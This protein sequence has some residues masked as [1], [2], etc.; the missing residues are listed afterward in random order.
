MLYRDGEVYDTQTLSEENDWCYRWTELDDSYTWTVDE[1]N[2]PKDYEKSLKQEGTHVTITNSH[3]NTH[4]DSP[5]TGDASFTGI[6]LAVAVLS[7]CGL[8]FT[9]LKGKKKAE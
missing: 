1:P 5:K 4:D 8:I 3:A 6:M 2:V 7:G 9:A